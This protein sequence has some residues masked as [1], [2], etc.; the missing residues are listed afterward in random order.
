MKQRTTIIFGN[1]RGIKNVLDSVSPFFKNIVR[2]IAGRSTK[3]ASDVIDNTFDD[4]AKTLK[5]KGFLK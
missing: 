2:K 1:K 3:L 4:F 5:D